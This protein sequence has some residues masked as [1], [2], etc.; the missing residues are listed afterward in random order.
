MNSKSVRTTTL[1]RLISLGIILSSCVS[2]TAQ[3]LYDYSPPPNYFD[4]QLFAPVGETAFEGR[5]NASEG[6]FFNAER[7]HAW[8]TRPDRGAL[9]ADPFDENGN[10]I[11][12]A[13]PTSTD[14]LFNQ[15]IDVDGDGTADLSSHLITFVNG[16]GL[17]FQFNGISDANPN[18]GSGWGNR[19]ELGWVEDGRG[20]M[21]SILS[22][23]RMSDTM[24]FGIDDKRINQLGSAQ[25]LN[26]VDG[27]PEGG[28]FD[29]NGQP[30]PTQPVDPVL[31]A[32]AQSIPSIDGLKTVPVFFDDPFGL[33]AG[34]VDLDADG[35]ADDLNG[36]GVLSTGTNG[37]GDQVRIGIVYDDVTINNR[38]DMSGVELMA[39]RRKKQLHGGA[40]AEMFVGARYLELDDRFNWVGR[41]GIFEETRMDNNALNRIV[42]PQVGFRI[43]KRTDRWSTTV[44]ARFMA[45]AN[46]MS[47]NQKGV[48]GSHLVPGNSTGS[49][50]GF[51]GFGGGLGTP[52]AAGGNEYFNRFSDERF[53]PTGEMRFETAFQATNAIQLKVGWQGM[54]IGGVARGSNTVVYSLP[55]MGILD[56]HEEIFSH[57]VTFGFE[58]NR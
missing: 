42:G 10:P 23:L 46:F 15:L 49:F 3:H 14:R 7:M 53:S 8:I 38:S 26:G 13:L 6:F 39:I 48:T 35:F 28:G 33:L 50:F 19:L 52:T 37:I 56:R 36:D 47:I 2:A 1:W 43:D 55:T 54:V 21:V 24:T 45:G 31:T 5:V 9:G 17:G 34:F 57:A 4:W 22:G 51:F 12:A 41:G 25:G 27:D 30:I 32:N 58:V 40:T 44:N 18:T 11:P 20:Y 29:A 16:S